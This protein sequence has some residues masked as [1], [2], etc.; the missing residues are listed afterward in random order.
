MTAEEILEHYPSLTPHLVCESLGYFTPKS[1][2]LAIQARQQGRGCACEWYIHMSGRGRTL[3]EVGADT[4][5]RAFQNRRHHR[6]YMA[7]YPHAR[8]LVE[9]ESQHANPTMMSSWQ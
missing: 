8:E 3:L 5:D 7:H 1:A 4:L 9:M 6:G 2:A